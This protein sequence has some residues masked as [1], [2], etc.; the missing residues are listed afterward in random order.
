VLATRVECNEE[1]N[2]FGDKSDGN[3]GGMR[4][5]VTRAMA[6]VTGDGDDMGVGDGD[7][8]GGRRRGQG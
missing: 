2:V 6:M 1:S 3:E 5:T 8:A 7:E 4:L